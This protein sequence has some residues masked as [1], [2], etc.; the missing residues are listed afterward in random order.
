MRFLTKISLAVVLAGPLLGFGSP[1]AQATVATFDGSFTNPTSVQTDTAQA[2]F[3][4]SGTYLT[5]VLT[6]TSTF[7]AYQNADALSGLFF[8][9]A[10]DPT[11]TGVSATASGLVRPPATSPSGSVNVDSGWGWQY[12]S[13]PY[14][15]SG[16]AGCPGGTLTGAG[17]GIAAAGYSCL[18][19]NFG[20]SDFG[21]GTSSNLKGLDYSIVG[22]AF[23]SIGGNASPL[24]ENAVTFV[25]S[26]LSAD[27]V[28]SDIS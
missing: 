3:S 17:Y 20:Q 14:T 13:A 25:F 28:L 5:V 2:V 6:N 8:Q 26:G 19:Q 16:A 4:A 7:G 12:S 1:A 15:F 11:L 18:D 27:F 24:A 21:T 23:T 22:S 10:G 9:I